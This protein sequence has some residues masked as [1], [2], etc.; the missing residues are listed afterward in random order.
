MRLS[1]V[2]FRYRR[3]DPLVIEDA[4]ARLAPGDVIELTGV[5]GAGK[6][7]LLRLLAGLARPTTGTIADR[8]PVVGFAPDRFPASQPFTVT[9]YLRHMSRVR[10]G[11]RWEPWIER[12][13]MGHLL[14][15]P[16]AD[17]SKGSAHKVGLAQALMAEPGLL[18]LDEPFAGLDADTREA[19]PSIA[20]E[21]A[22]RG[23]VVI[24]SDHQ[25]GMRGL[26]GLRHW[27]MVDGH[28]KEGTAAPLPAATA[29][30]TTQATAQATATAAH[31]TVAVTLPA[32]ELRGF[33]ARMREEGFQ[34]RE[35]E[36][37]AAQNEETR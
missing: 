16:L 23:G 24:A 20:T 18:I 4:D 25:G 6:S 22:G 34:A 5:N 29:Q 3:R 21:V 36:T 30:A 27:S 1:K 8:P 9:A 12:L 13:N 31:A 32:R 15:T 14:A 10:G 19:L 2:S 17:L 26:P 11:G 33:L 35:V 28:L 37:A 7:T